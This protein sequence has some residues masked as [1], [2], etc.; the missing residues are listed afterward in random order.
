[1]TD[2]PLKANAPA[3]SDEHPINDC[4]NRIGVWAENGATCDRLIDAIHCRNCETFI[5]A[6]RLIFE[7][8]SSQ[9]YQQENLVKYSA[10]ETSNEGKSVGVIVIRLG[11]ELFALPVGVLE[12]IT[13]SKP[14]H[15]LPHMKSAF[16]KGVVNIAGEVCL[17]HSLATVLDVDDYTD[18]DE[19]AGQHI[20][21][22]LMVVNIDEFR[23]VFP[24]DEIKGMTEYQSESLRAA[25]ATISEEIKQLVSGAF[26]LL[27][28]DV[29]VLDAHKLH[30]LLRTG[31]L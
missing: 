6:G 4:W 19:H 23:Y 29:A 10:V 3:P 8:E 12:V 15:R 18:N 11:P 16:I 5:A 17:C 20:Y 13:D 2:K 30:Q 21:R 28:Q 22:R 24:V 7:R 25:P 26:Q 27:G 9:E 14:V 1:M 31:L